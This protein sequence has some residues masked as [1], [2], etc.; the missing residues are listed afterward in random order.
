EGRGLPAPPPG[1]DA[2]GGQRRLRPRQQRRVL[3]VVRHGDQRLPHRRGRTRHSCGRH[4]R[5]VRRV[6]LR[7]PRARHV[8]GD[9]R[10]RPAGRQARPLER[11]L[12]AG[13]LPGG[14]RGAC[15]AGM[16]RPRL[17]AA[18][19]PAT[20]PDPRRAAHGARTPAARGV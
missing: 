10:G 7:V 16:V 15:G 12:R 5:P 6:A 2:M 8:P 3:R 4:D 1:R 19:R 9:G 13:D 18:R 20:D 11:P 17:R 14:G